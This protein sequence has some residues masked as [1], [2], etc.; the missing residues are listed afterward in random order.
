MSEGVLFAIHYKP[1]I[2]LDELTNVYSFALSPM[3][4][5]EILEILE[6]AGCVRVHSKYITPV[7]KASPFKGLLLSIPCFCRLTLHLA[8]HN[9]RIL[10]KYVN[11]AHDGIQRFAH[12]YRDVP[13]P[14]NVYVRRYEDGHV[15]RSPEKQILD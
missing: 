8:G 14:Q 7:T 12:F 4:L 6:A 15:L 10:V 13:L 1:G 3:L 9:E 2:R 11:P 5:E